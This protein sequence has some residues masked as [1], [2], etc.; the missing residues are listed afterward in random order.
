MVLRFVQSI[1]SLIPWLTVFSVCS[2]LSGR[3]SA[4]GPVPRIHDYLKRGASTCPTQIHFWFSNYFHIPA[5]QIK[6]EFH[7]MRLNF[8]AVSF[9][10]FLLFGLIVPKRCNQQTDS[11]LALDHDKS[12][13]PNHFSQ[14]KLVCPLLQSVI[15]SF[16]PA[17]HSQAV[18]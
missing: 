7:S 16:V 14:F 5:H 3:F 4:F 1:L 12:K 18:A 17:T 9:I 15:R 10:S 6:A 13:H 2:V 11:C 8:L